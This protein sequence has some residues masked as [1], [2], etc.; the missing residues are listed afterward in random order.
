MSKPQ[1]AKAAKAAIEA[2]IDIQDIS[3]DGEVVWKLSERE[4]EMQ[5]GLK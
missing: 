4:L 5:R 1:A 2:G 3:D